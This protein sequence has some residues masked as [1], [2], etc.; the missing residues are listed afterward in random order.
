M[1]LIRKLN[2]K[3]MERNSIHGEIGAT[4]TVFETD[5]RAFVQ[6]DTYGSDDRQMPGKKS[7]TLQLD[8]SAGRQLV[9]ILRDAFRIRD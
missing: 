6:I 1:A 9:Q 2:A 7:Q 3:Q 8:E 4:Y 5:G